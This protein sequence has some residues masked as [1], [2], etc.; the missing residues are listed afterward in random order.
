MNWFKSKYFCLKSVIFILTVGGICTQSFSQCSPTINT[1]PYTENF[2]TS[3]GNWVAGGTGSDWAWGTPAK[4][5]IS[6]AGSGVKCWIVGGLSGSSYISSERSYVVSPCFDFSSL[7]NPYITF[8]I[9]WET[10]KQYD[11]G[12]FEYSINGGTSWTNVSSYNAAIDCLND[13]GYNNASI[14]NLTGLANPKAGWS[15]NVQATMGSCLGGGGSNGWRIAKQTMPF[16]AGQTQVL[17][18]FTFG[19]GSTCNAYDGLAFDDILIEEAPATFTLNYTSQLAGCG[20]ADGSALVNIVGGIAPFSYVWNPNVSTNNIITNV[21][22]GNYNLLVTDAGGCTKSMVVI[23]GQTPAVTIS[24]TA[25]DDTCAQHIGVAQLLVSG[26][27]PPYSIA[28]TTGDTTSTVLNLTNGNYSVTVTDSRNCSQTQNFIINDV[29]N[30]TIDLGE[31]KIECGN[32]SV[33]LSAGNF[34]GYLWQDS[35]T[36]ATFDAT[37]EGIYFVQVQNNSGCTASDTVR[38]TTDCVDDVFVPNAFTPNDDKL[39]E[40]FLAYGE[41]IKSFAMMIYDRWGQV[42]FE[43]SDINTGWNGKLNN[44]KL[45]QGLYVWRITFSKDGK[46][47]KTKKGTVFLVR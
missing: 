4:P 15:G 23:V 41:N 9:F 6:G 46:L 10:E 40:T 32:F 12:N 43:S 2:E 34:A 31:D 17:F 19:S 42:V 47:F 26:G 29:G 13:F 20:V 3:A 21:A 44:Q 11:G 30:F 16:L 27:T 38:I 36:N 7:V 24:V 28:W 25:F 8:K 14:T 45:R 39:N 18:R 1:F 22:A 35:S 5:V 33:K 37:T